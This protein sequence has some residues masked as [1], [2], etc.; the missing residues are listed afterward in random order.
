MDLLSSL[1]DKAESESSAHLDLNLS[2]ATYQLC[3]FDQ[4]TY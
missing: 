4:V 1:M 2:F 3:D